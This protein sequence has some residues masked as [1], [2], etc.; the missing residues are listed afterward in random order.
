MEAINIKCAKPG[1][2]PAVGSVDSATRDL[3][4]GDIIFGGLIG[5][6]VDMSTGAAYHYPGLISVVMNKAHPNP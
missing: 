4:F 2:A 3:A 1:F 5:A 6:G